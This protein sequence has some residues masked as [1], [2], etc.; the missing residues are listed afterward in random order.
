[1]EDLV[2]ITLIG[3]T[4]RRGRVLLVDDDAMLGQ[5]V[6][7]SLSGF[8]D[9]KV[10]SSAQEALDYIVGG[11]R[12]DVIL[13]DVM[14]PVV[15]GMDF[16]DELHQSVPEQAARIVFLTGGAF[17]VGAREFLDRVP[18]VR[19]EKP[20]D[21]KNLRALVNERVAHPNVYAVPA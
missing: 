21:V 10:L 12:F 8:H 19:M 15:T 1:V 13:C 11:Q 16:Y 9:V 17:T 2:P 7:R 3:A 5:A 18:N 20:F 6:G 4:T 14:M